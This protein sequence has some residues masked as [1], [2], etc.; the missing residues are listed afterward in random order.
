MPTQPP[1]RDP[2]IGTQMCWGHWEDAGLQWPG[3]SPCLTMCSVLHVC[4]AFCDKR[5]VRSRARLPLCG[6]EIGPGS[7]SP[8]QCLGGAGQCLGGAGR[9]WAGLGR[10]GYAFPTS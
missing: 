8:G 4:D 2:C 9:G 7:A 5:L 10:A 6:R 1:S 3:L